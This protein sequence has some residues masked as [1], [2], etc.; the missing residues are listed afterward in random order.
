[1]AML[2]H[3]FWKQNKKNV[4]FQGK[5][6]LKKLFSSATFATRE[7][8]LFM[9]RISRGIQLFY[10]SCPFVREQRSRTSWTFEFWTFL[11]IKL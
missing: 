9:I 1:M 6:T 3:Y 11:D 7:T 4:I 10:L 5:N 8:V 2:I